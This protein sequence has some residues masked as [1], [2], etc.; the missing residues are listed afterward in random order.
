[1]KKRRN[2]EEIKEVDSALNDEEES[3]DETTDEEEE[4]LKNEGRPEED[5]EGRNP[6]WNI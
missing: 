4:S 5:P 1:M 3:L 6:R 2:K